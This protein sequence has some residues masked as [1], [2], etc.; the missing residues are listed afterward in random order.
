[1]SETKDKILCA[2]PTPGKAPT[3]IDRWKHDRV[4]TAI[5]SVFPERGKC[6]AAATTSLNGKLA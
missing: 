1:M 4:R 6:S 5:L 2:T 3:R